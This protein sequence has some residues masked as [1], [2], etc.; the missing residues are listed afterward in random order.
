MDPI[1]TQGNIV[2]VK[3]AAMDVY[4]YEMFEAEQL[5][6]ER[7]C[8]KQEH[9]ESLEE[10]PFVTVPNDYGTHQEFIYHLGRNKDE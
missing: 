5:R 2:I 9:E 8:S 1:L 3:G 7:L 4:T 6:R 10:L